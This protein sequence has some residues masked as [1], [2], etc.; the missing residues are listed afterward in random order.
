MLQFLQPGPM[1]QIIKELTMTDRQILDNALEFHGHKCW[2]PVLGVR[3]GLAAMRV[4]GVERSS[5]SEL[6]A[7]VEVGEEHG[8]MCF[9][10]GIQSATG[11]TFGKGNIRREL[12]GKLGFTLIDKNTDRGVRVHY[13]PNLH[14]EIA[15][16]AY[17][18]QRAA[19]IPS[20][21]IP[22]EDREG[23]VNLVWEAPED[24]VL[25]IDEIFAYERQWYPYDM[26]FRACDSCGEFTAKAYLRVVGDKAMCI[27]CSGYDR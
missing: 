21:E 18:K 13:K 2:A 22:D 4:L 3:I 11:C 25:E 24:E 17:V 10:D 16:S 8:G 9:T 1:K 15:Q 14:K 5:G 26:G 27:P 20:D 23:V 7:I 12:Y 6:Y 19:G